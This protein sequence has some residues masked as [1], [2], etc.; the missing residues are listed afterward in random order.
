MDNERKSLSLCGVYEVARHEKKALSEKRG[1]GM[2][3]TSLFIG[4]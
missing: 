3:A 2:F 4:F 1:T